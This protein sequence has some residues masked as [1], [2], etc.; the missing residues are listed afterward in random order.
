MRKPVTLAAAVVLA[1]VLAA[2]AQA[3]FHNVTISNAATSCPA[4]WSGGTPDVFT[5]TAD[6]ANVQV[7]DLTGRLATGN[8]QINTTAAGGAEAGTITVVNS[9]SWSSG[10][11]L[12]LK[13]A[14]GVPIN[15]SVS[16]TS[17]SLDVNA[18][19]AITQAGAITLPSASFTTTAGITLPNAANDYFNLTVSAGGPVVLSD[20]TAVNLP[21][22]TVTGPNAF[23]LTTGGNITQSGAI[24][25]GGD[26][27]FT[28]SSG[29]ITLPSASNSFAGTLTPHTTGPSGSASITAGGAMAIGSGA[30]VGGNAT[31]VS[32]GSLT[33]AGPLTVGGTTTLQLSNPSSDITLSDANDLTGAVSVPGGVHDLTLRNVHAGASFG[34]L[35]ASLHNFVLTL[36]GAGF[37]FPAMSVS[38]FL[39]VD[40]TGPITQTGAISVPAQAFYTTENGTPITL[41]NP[42]NQFPGPQRFRVLGGTA[43]ISVVADDDLGLAFGS[44]PGNL[45]VV[46]GGRISIPTGPLVNVGGSVT[47]VTDADAAAP[48]IGSG[49]ITMTNAQ[50][51]SGGPLAI[52]TA[53]RSQNSIDAPSR[54][55]GVAFTPGT[56]F[57]D[58]A[59]E[60]WNTRFPAG[61][62][63][64]PYT[65]FYKDAAPPVEQ[66]PTEQPPAEQPPAE[67]PPAEQP[68][69]PVA[70]NTKIDSAPA[71]KVRTSKRRLEVKFEFSSDVAG[72]TFRCELDGHRQA[73]TS[74]FTA[75]VKKS[76]HHF[77][78][79]A[80]A[81]GLTDPTPA[82]VNFKV[83]RRHHH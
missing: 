26:T 13:A 53:R 4:C 34:T 82:E 27:T 37:A 49:G 41:E 38:S 44:T 18:G 12:S 33:Q 32:G 79:V 6:S 31:F 77:E 65:I 68:V 1:L 71:S 57:A 59:R 19:G 7:S 64:N 63:T 24:A 39:N 21:S 76:R 20:A 8:V 52:Y 58:T 75:R 55:N 50:L 45:K 46:A 47:L 80:T 73:C 9:V 10:K 70:P 83:L 40:V 15:A 29:S 42:A 60:A 61:T 22:V 36:N 69:V 2:P 48:A 25:V 35:P 67:Q 14:A 51:V 72:S 16:A 5:P 78:V 17:G 11:T 81:N 23:T 30:Q 74:P 28:A 56:E 62:A 3:A 66:P 43:N 54:L